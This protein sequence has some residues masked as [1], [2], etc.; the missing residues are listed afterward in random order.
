MKTIHFFPMFILVCMTG[1]APLY[2]GYRD[3]AKKSC[4]ELS[5][6][7]E[8]IDCRKNYTMSYDQYE[9][10]R[11]SLQDDQPQ[12]KTLEK[13]KPNL[14]FKRTSTGQIECPN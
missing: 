10:Q 3:Q 2:T 11:Q 5:S 9:K 14:C 1:C 7:P 4:D 6:I 8:R 13:E 12:K